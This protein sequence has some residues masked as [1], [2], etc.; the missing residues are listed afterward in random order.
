MSHQMS[1]QIKPMKLP[2]YLAVINHDEGATRYVSASHGDLITRI[3]DYCREQ[4]P[5]VSDSQPPH[6]TRDIIEAYFHENPKDALEVSEDRIELP[7]P[8]ASAPKLL[9]QLENFLAA[10][11]AYKPGDGEAF[12]VLCREVTDTRAVIASAFIPGSQSFTD[13]CQGVGGAV[14]IEI[15]H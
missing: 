10:L 15:L 13:F 3:G 12:A 11:L 8:Y 2:I 6:D 14:D 7:K 1:H 4:W 9:S 5:S